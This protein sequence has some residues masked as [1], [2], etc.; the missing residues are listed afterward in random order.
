[1]R[2]LPRGL[3]DRRT[4]VDAHELARA[5]IFEPAFDTGAAMGLLNRLGI[6]FD[7]WMPIG[8]AENPHKLLPSWP[9][10]EHR[11]GAV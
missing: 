10:T 3:R 4:A 8:L 5:L 11:S 2:C 7:E 1:M 9:P 6:T